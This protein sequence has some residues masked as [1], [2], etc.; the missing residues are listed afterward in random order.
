MKKVTKVL[1]A[2]MIAIT[3]LSFQSCEGCKRRMKTYKSD[4]TGLQRKAVLYDYQGNVLKQWTGK[5]DIN[6]DGADRIFFDLDGKRIWIQGGIFVA[7][8]Q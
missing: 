2:S 6:D 5:F 4:M 7:E 1:V 3:M 8:E